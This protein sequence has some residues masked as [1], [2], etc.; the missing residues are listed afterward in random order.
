MQILFFGRRDKKAVDVVAK[1]DSPQTSSVCLPI[2]D[3]KPFLDEIP[4]SAVQ[5][6]L[7]LQGKRQMDWQLYL[8]NFLN[9]EDFKAKLTRRGYRG[10]PSSLSPMVYSGKQIAKLDSGIQKKMLQKRKN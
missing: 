2:H 7:T 3:I 6:I 8:E 9:Y 1:L 4:P 5:K 10:M